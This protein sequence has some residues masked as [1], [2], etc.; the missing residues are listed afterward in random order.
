MIPAVPPKSN[1]RAPWDYD[2]ELYK[3]RNQVE[4][5]FRRLKGFRRICSRFKKL[6]VVFLAFIYFAFIIG[7]LLWAA[8]L[9]SLSSRRVEPVGAYCSPRMRRLKSITPYV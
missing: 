1:R 7:A 8:K 3:K 4:R 2:R 9:T 5:L 6:D